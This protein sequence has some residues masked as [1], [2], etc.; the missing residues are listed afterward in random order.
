M[1][2]L[3][4]DGQ[5]TCSY[6]VFGVGCGPGEPGD[7]I[8]PCIWKDHIFNNSIMV[9]VIG[10]T[11]S[12]NATAHTCLVKNETEDIIAVDNFLNTDLALSELGEATCI[13]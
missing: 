3:M 8:N 12:F 4:T 1:I 11:D 2:V 9:K 13:C 5:P 6:E 7:D 10:L